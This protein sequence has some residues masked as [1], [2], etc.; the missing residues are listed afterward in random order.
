MPGSATLGTNLVDEL[1]GDV[2]DS[3]RDD[4]HTEFG[5]RA[6]RVYT[7]RRAWTGRRVGEGRKTDVVTEITPQPAVHRWDGFELE[8]AQCGL[9]EIGEVRL[10]EVSLTYTYD[11]LTGGALPDN[12]QWFIRLS[13]AHGQLNPDRYFVFTRPPYPDREKT[14]GWVLWLRASEAP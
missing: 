13:E 7:V 4:L 1:V 2:V 6:F 9:D 14:L 12:V 11:E 5:V 3:L 8:L 10:S